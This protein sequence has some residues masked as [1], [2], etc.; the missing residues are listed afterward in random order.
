MTLLGHTARSSR[1]SAFAVFRRRN[2]ALLWIAQFIST[3]GSGLTALAASILVYRLTGSAFSVGLMLL[4]TALPGLLVGLFAGVFVDRFDRKRIMVA[5]NLVCAGLVCAIP[6]VL[7]LGVTWLFIVVALSSAVGQFFAPAQASILPE[8][9]PDEELAAANSMMTISQFGA[10]TAGYAGAGLIATLSTLTW[11]FYLDALSFVLSALCILPIRV[12]PLAVKRETNLATVAHNLRAGLGFVRDTPVLR[13]LVLVFVPIFVSYGFANS[14]FLPFAIRALGATEF[15][16]S[17]LEGVFTIGFVV[18]SLMLV[19]LVDRLHAGQWIAVSVLG[20]GLFNVALALAWSAPLAI[21]LTLIV[22]IVNAPSYVGRQLL[23]QRSTPREAR[24]RVS[25]V[26]FVTRD[27]GFML[28]MAAAGLADLIDVRA[29]MLVNAALLIG[30]GLLALALPGLGQPSAEWRRMLAMLRTAPAAPGLGLGRAALVSDIDLLVMH[31]PA[32]AH[33]SRQERQA[34]AAQARV[35]DAPAGTAIVRQGDQ[36]DAVNL[37]LGGRTV[38]SRAQDGADGVLEVQNAGDFFGEIAALTGMA[39]TATVL[40]ELPTSV[41]QVPAMAL[42]KLTRDPQFNRVFLS[43][44]TERMV[45]TNMVDLPRFAGLDQ[46]T[47]QELRTSGPP[48]LPSPQPA[49]ATV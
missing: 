19:N 45:R 34:L 31:L 30:C 35:F 2:F 8:T 6:L 22:G 42:R 10:L 1:S 11:A 26:F 21:T 38:A 18:G 40:A 44:L 17:L 5:S 23:I 46:A 37:I 4:A 49:P 48:A 29:L 14:L 24:G 15:E 7:P 36:S 41:L 39:R 27:T 16:Y 3:L 13:S 20:M 12:A 47:L 9:A 25:S 43:K 33:A 32:L 28:G